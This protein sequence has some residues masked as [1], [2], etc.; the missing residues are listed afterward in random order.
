LCS[1]YTPL[2]YS[3]T[4]LNLLTLPPFLL[5]ISCSVTVFNVSFWGSSILQVLVQ[6]PVQREHSWHALWTSLFPVTLTLF[7]FILL[8][9]AC[10]YWRWLLHLFERLI[11]LGIRCH[12]WKELIC[13]S[14][15]LRS[16][17]GSQQVVC[18][19]SPFVHAH[20]IWF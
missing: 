17:C 18:K 1:S 7:Y 10:H 9:S 16:V 6:M 4:F 5:L 19:H 11:P 3:L 2:S 13:L 14:W 8:Q 20:T 12:D 15:V